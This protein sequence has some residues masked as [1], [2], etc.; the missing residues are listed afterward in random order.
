VAQLP[1]AAAGNGLRA[2]VEARRQ[3]LAC[4]QPHAIDAGKAI[5]LLSGVTPD[6]EQ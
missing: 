2:R 6:A 3:S 4:R 5:E 1:Q